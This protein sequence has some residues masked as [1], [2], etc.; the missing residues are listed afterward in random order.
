MKTFTIFA[1]CAALACSA[2]AQAAPAAKPTGKAAPVASA[3]ANNPALHGFWK[4][5][6]AEGI[7]LPG[8]ME[9]RAD[10]SAELS[11]KGEQTLKGS[12]VIKGTELTLTMPPYGVA[13]MQYAISSKGLTLTYE[14]GM[15]QKFVKETIKK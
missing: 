4:S 8:T 12:W 6:N 14:N 15:K 3:T 10:G 9:L 11:P 1:L 7:I 13:K 5:V 2:A